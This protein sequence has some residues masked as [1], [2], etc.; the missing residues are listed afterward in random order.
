MGTTRPE[1][2]D[3]WAEI[4]RAMADSNRLRILLAAHHSPGID[5]TGLADAVGHDGERH[6]ARLAALRV[7]GMIRSERVGRERRW[8]SASEQ[9]HSLL[10]DVGATHPPRQPES[11][12]FGG[13]TT[14]TD[15]GRKPSGW[16]PNSDCRPDCAGRAAWSSIRV[17]PP[18]SPP[19]PCVRH[20]AGGRPVAEQ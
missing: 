20:R 8:S 6:L 13:G 5:V 2:I 7:R 18:G 14:L 3:G 9:I 1:V 17:A 15:R 11:W 4:F 19:I 10:H 16:P 12:A